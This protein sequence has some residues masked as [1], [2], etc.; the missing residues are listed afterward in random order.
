MLLTRCFQCGK[1]MNEIESMYSIIVIV[2]CKLT[3]ENICVECFN[4]SK[5]LLEGEDGV[6]AIKGE[7]W[8]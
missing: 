8:K 2:D 7:V 6:G 1:L 5:L 3:N 4:N